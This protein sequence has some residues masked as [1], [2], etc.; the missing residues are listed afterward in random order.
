VKV[1][2]LSDAEQDLRDGFSFYDRQTRG[3]GDYFIRSLLADLRNL[4]HLAGIH[5]QHRGYH[6]MLASRFHCAIYYKI[7]GDTAYVWAI[8]DTRQDP[9]KTEQ[10]LA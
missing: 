2:L 8:L 6:R 9:S 5:A 3:L 1:L 7:G 10:R 4:G